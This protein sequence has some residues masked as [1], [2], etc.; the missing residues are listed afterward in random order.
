[1]IQATSRRHRLWNTMPTSGMVN[2]VRM[3]GRQSTGSV[4]K[5]E[6]GDTH[7][8]RNETSAPGWTT[9]REKTSMRSA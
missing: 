4:E 7:T 2:R 1:L 8:P 9:R 5:P 6:S 3:P